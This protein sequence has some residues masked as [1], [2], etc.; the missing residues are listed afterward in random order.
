MLKII[1]EVP[2][3]VSVKLVRPVTFKKGI[4]QPGQ[5]IVLDID[6]KIGLVDGFHV[7]LDIEDFEVVMPN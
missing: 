4:G 2:C 6:N 5:I 3:L 7:Q 1:D